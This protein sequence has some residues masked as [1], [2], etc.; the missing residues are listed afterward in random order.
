M[1]SFPVKINFLIHNMVQFSSTKHSEA[2]AK[3]QISSNTNIQ[4]AVIQKYTVNGKD[5]VSPSQKPATRPVRR[6]SVK[7]HLFSCAVSVS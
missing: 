3:S 5:V 1:E 6:S 4:E 2:P 7:R